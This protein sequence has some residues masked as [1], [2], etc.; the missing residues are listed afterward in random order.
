MNR[1]TDTCSNTH[2]AGDMMK[3]TE[4]QSWIKILNVF[5]VVLM[6]CLNH[7]SKEKRCQSQAQNLNHTWLWEDKLSPLTAAAAREEDDRQWEWKR[8]ER[9]GINF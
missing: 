3:T 6:A 2:D 7:Y 4:P 5:F 1:L 9:G 8:R